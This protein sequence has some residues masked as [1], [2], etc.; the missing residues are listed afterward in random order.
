MSDLITGQLPNI[1]KGGANPLRAAGQD[2]RRRAFGW[3]SSGQ[4]K[5]SDGRT[6]GDRRC[7][8][9]TAD[10]TETDGEE[11]IGRK[12]ED[13]GKKHW[14]ERNPGESWWGERGGREPSLE[15]NHSKLKIGTDSRVQHSR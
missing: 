10:N 14:R 5:T 1:P 11:A 6:T 3:N 15:V 2:T 7:W 9:W 12:R 8:R 4:L 13:T